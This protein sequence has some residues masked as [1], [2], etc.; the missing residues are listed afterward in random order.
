MAKIVEWSIYEEFTSET[1]PPEGLACLLGCNPVL[2]VYCQSPTVPASTLLDVEHADVKSSTTVRGRT[3]G[4]LI[5]KLLLATYLAPDWRL[6]IEYN[7]AAVLSGTLLPSQ[8]CSVQCLDC[9]KQGDIAT[10]GEQGP[11]GEQAT[12]NFD[13]GAPDTDFSGGPGFDCGGVT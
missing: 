13:G 8:I 1:K 5:A 2:A 7:D 4:V 9:E 3:V 11:P 6:R 12:V 10:G